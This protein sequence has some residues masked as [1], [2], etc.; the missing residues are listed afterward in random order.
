MDQ[1]G[2]G[3]GADGVVAVGEAAVDGLGGG[4]EEDGVGGESGKER[5][6]VIDDGLEGNRE[7][8]GGCT[9]L[10]ECAA[11]GWRG[12]CLIGFSLLRR[13]CY[14]WRRVSLLL[15]WWWC[16]RCC[17]NCSVSAGGGSRH[18]SCC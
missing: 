17:G 6:S 5:K 3:N 15:V 12:W 4:E 11:V 9:P 10:R 8:E 16:H 1:A 13:P 7:G 18:C 14:S 2:G